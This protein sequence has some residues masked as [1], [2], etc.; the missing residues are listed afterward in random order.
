MNPNQLIITKQSDIR[1]YD[2][3]TDVSLQPGMF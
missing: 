2:L 1:M 3:I